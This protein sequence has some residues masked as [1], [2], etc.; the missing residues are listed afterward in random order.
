[1]S[2]LDALDR[3]TIGELVPLL[4]RAVGLDP[5][6]L[7]RLRGT[8]SALF[9]FLSVFDVLVAR[10]VGSEARPADLSYYAA[11]LVAW[12][13][14]SLGAPQRKDVDWRG[15]LPPLNGWRR[16]ETIPD[17][18]IRPLVRSGA[19]ALKEA[20]A[21]G[22]GLSARNDVAEALLNSIV[23]TVSDEDA[24][25]SVELT[26]RMVSALTRMGFLPRGGSAGVDVSGGWTRLAA[27]YG[28][29]YARPSGLRLG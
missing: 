3:E 14:G 8:G 23:L 6:V 25:K 26:L 29:V 4:R 28:S 22:P 11:E 7:V 17:E 20:G 15:S 9:A 2:E 24:P 10:G 1:M 13:E 21:R 12:A 16:I 27:G 19:L 18:T 5:T